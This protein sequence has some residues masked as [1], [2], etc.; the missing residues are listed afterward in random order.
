MPAMRV[1]RPRTLVLS[2][3]V[4]ALAAVSVGALQREL[5]PRPR[6]AAAPMVFWQ[7]KPLQKPLT[8]DEESY[9][10]ALWPIQAELVETS[11]VAMSFAGMAYVTEGHDAQKLATSA[12]TLHEKF[13][14]ADARTKAL[15]TPESMLPVQQRY[16]GAISAFETASAEMAKV[17]DDGKLEHLVEAQA[18][19]QRAAEDLLRVGDVLWPGEHKPN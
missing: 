5:A 2:L 3:V 1:P 17:G 13:A 15:S 4:C 11:A 9:A 6:A 19:S 12:R 8:A 18:M 10:E 14:M 16:L 7:G